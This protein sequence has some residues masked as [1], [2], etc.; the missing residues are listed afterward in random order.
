MRNARKR[1]QY[2]SKLRGRA[3]ELGLSLDGTSTTTFGNGKDGSLAA[4]ELIASASN[5]GTN[6]DPTAAMV[7][8][9]AS[10]YPLANVDIEFLSYRGGSAKSA[11]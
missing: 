3:S 5:G 6:R 4:L 7:Q 8:D 11:T 10:E 1:I 9:I 2:L